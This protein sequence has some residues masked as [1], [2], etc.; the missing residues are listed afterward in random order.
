MPTFVIALAVLLADEAAATQALDAFKTAPK[1]S[2]PGGR[3]AAILELAKTDHPRVAAKLGLLLLADIPEARIAAAKGLALQLEDPKKTVPQLL[4][5]AQAHAKVPAILIPVV[6]SL[7]KLGDPDGAAEVNK[8]LSASDIDLVKAAVEAA[9]RIRSASSLDP[10]IKALKDCDELLVPRNPNQP[11]GD[12]LGRLGGPG[13]DNPREARERA[14]ELQPLLKAA[15]AGI[16]EVQCQDG[17][18][19]ESWWKENRAK[20]KPRS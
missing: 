2:D 3:A 19:Y 7:G 14:R 4:K 17:K 13:G 12:L 18:D 5:G 10:L 8:H 6:E 9:T 15:L 11:R 1:A 16:T 20:F